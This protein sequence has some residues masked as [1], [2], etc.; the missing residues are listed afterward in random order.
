MR[1]DEPGAAGSWGP[2]LHWGQGLTGREVYFSISNASNNVIYAGFY[3]A[4]LRT[5]SIVPTNQW[6]HVAWIRTGANGSNAGTSLLINGRL[7]ATEIDTT[8]NPGVLS[9]AQIAVPASPFQIN[10]ASDFTNLRFFTGTLDEVALHDR[11][12]TPTQVRNTALA[13][14][15]PGVLGCDGDADGNGA[16][17]F[18]DLNIVLSQFGQMGDGLDGDV[19]EDAN[20]N[21][22]DLNI[23]LSN[24][25]IVCP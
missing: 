6:M 7:V 23:V 8:L 21:F 3:N 13:A 9:S 18:T 15:V 24:F 12:L 17:N 2:F 1:L 19:N 10:R 11:R 25:G 4:G 5:A 22:A 16:V 20:V 14:A